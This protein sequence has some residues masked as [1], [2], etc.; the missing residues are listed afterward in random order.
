MWEAVYI[1]F[2][3]SIEIAARLYSMDK[4]KKEALK[5]SK[6]IAPLMSETCQNTCNEFFLRAAQD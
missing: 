6:I 1:V 3:R 4:K 2:W 5:M